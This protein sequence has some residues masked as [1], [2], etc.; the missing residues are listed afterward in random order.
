MGYTTEDAIELMAECRRSLEERLNRQAFYELM[1]TYRLT[2]IGDQAGVTSAFEAVKIFI[3]S[4][5]D[6]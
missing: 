4:P 6:K 5:I 2:P 1:Q 3:L